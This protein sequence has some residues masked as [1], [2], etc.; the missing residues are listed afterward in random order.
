MTIEERERAYREARERIFGKEG[1]IEGVEIGKLEG[2]GGESLEVLG[3]GKERER[4]NE[5]TDSSQNTFSSTSTSN[6]S[7]NGISTTPNS[8]TSSSYASSASNSK[9]KTKPT[10]QVQRTN[11]ESNEEKVLD[12]DRFAETEGRGFGM[13]YSSGNTNQYQ[14]GVGYPSNGYSGGGQQG[15]QQMNVGGPSTYQGQ[16]PTGTENQAYQYQPQVSGYTQPYD[17][18]AQYQPQ[19]H[20][21][22]PMNYPQPIQYQGLPSSTEENTFRNLRPG[23]KIFDPNFNKSMSYENQYPALGSS[24]NSRTSTNNGKQKIKEKGRERLNQCLILRILLLEKVVVILL[25]RI[26]L[27]IIRII[28]ILSLG[29]RRIEER[30]ADSQMGMVKW[31]LM[32]IMFTIGI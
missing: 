31:D 13:L 12:L 11:E 18:S 8:S 17:P 14:N 23:A 21:P 29:M 7:S 28:R 25:F 3:N 6:E 1:E 26:K 5:L 22:Y 9:G 30:M 32:G 15:Y 24:N 27:F 2:V 4:G 19:P 10:H 16:V 20:H